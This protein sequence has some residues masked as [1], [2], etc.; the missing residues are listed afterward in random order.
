MYSNDVE[1]KQV[2]ADE[3]R[4]GLLEDGV[5]QNPITEPTKADV[6]EIAEY[7]GCNGEEL[8][9]EVFLLLLQQDRYARKDELRKLLK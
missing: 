4:K 6:Q 2:K 8:W 9:S 5:A 7:L 3:I 1:N